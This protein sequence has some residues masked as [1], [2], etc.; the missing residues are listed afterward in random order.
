MSIRLKFL[1]PLVN[2]IYL[3]IKLFH[4]ESEA[5]EWLKGLLFI[6]DTQN[7]AFVLNKAHWL[8]YYLLRE[9]QLT[10]QAMG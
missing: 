3:Q 2:G 8:P 9:V 10:L 5:V 6:V 7:H 1:F 4:R